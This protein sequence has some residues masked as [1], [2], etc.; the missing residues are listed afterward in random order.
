MA[1]ATE[2]AIETILDHLKSNKFPERVILVA[3]TDKD[4]KIIKKILQAYCQ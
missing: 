4:L 2:V 1:E 3:F